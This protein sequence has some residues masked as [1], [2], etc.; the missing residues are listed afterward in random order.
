MPMRSSLTMVLLLLVA[1]VTRASERILVVAHEGG[2]ERTLRYRFEATNTTSDPVA[3]AHLL[4]YLPAATATQRLLRVDVSH[5]AHLERDDL[6][7]AWVSIALPVLPPRAVVPVSITAAIAVDDQ[8]RALDGAD[9]DALAPAPY[10]ESTDP[11]VI[12]L[13]RSLPR[14]SEAWA[15]AR[16]VY[17][18]V[19]ATVTPGV[20]EPKDLGAAHALASRSGDCTEMAYATVALARA[21]GLPARLAGGWVAPRSTLLSPGGYHNWAEIHDGTTWRV[22]DAHGRSFGE[23][24]ERY[25]ATH[26]GGIDHAGPLRGFHRFRAD[27]PALALRM[28][29]AP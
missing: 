4:V 24:P 2:Q 28:L 8:P 23:H 20:F 11:A 14:T 25:V 12:A 21:A 9:P 7:N 29:G 16:A 6:G 13:A 5:A 18:L 22:V 15:T 1:P 19:L 17:D 26:L 27:H 3:G 10:I